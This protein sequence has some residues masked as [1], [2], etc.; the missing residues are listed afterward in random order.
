M[1]EIDK[2]LKIIFIFLL[3]YISL[4]PFYYFPSFS[5]FGIKI[6]LIKY[7]PLFLILFLL[8]IS[9]LEGYINIKAIKKERLNIYILIYFFITLFSG[10]GTTYYPISML[11]SIYYGL[12]GIL[13]YFI[14]YSWDLNQANKLRFLQNIV[15]LGFIVSLYGIITLVLGRDI[16]FEKLQYSKSHVID[17]KF[18]LEM[19]RISSSFGNPHFLGSFLSAIFPISFYLHLHALEKKILSWHTAVMSIF[20]FIGITLT[21]SVGAFLGVIVFY[22]FYHIKIKTLYKKL[23]IYDYKM[24]EISFLLGVILLCAVLTMMTT[25]ILLYLYKGNYLFGKFLGR[26]DFHKLANIHGFIYRSDSIKYAFDSL[27]TNCFFGMGI[28]KIGVGNNIFSRIT[29]DN[30]YCLSLIE[31]GLIPFISMLIISYLIIKKG[32][33][34]FKNVT[35]MEQKRLRVFLIGSFAMFFINMFFWDVFNHPTIRI[36]FW[37]FV[38]FLI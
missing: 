14:I 5:Y 25:N 6:P 11:K 24:T 16:L 37:L 18:F 3:G 30:F 36:L 28:G 38:G 35:L 4:I 1:N 20:I 19:G 26:I 34:K 10:I 12:T 9:F 31:S 21:F 2:I 33:D 13:V 27:R 29:M 8:I 32:Y 22:I 15:I 7:L 17:P 23:S